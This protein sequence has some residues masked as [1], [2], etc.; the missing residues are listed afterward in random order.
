MIVKYI[1]CL[2]L[3]HFML[4]DIYR[5][6]GLCGLHV[7]AWVRDMNERRLIEHILHVLC[8]S[9]SVSVSVSVSVRQS[10][11]WRKACI[12]IYLYYWLTET[13]RETMVNAPHSQHQE[14]YD[15]SSSCFWVWHIQRIKW[16]RVQ[17]LTQ[18]WP[19]TIS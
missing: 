12:H 1:A 4:P 5:V 16:T 3:H 8:V 15:I 17:Q 10:W 18:V 7:K 9:L 11:L 14:N 2:I 13:T 6:V 19:E